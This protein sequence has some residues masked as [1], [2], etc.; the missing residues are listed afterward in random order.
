MCANRSFALRSK[1]G[2]KSADFRQTGRRPIHSRRSR[3]RGEY[4]QSSSGYNELGRK[5]YF[6]T[7]FLGGLTNAVAVGG[8]PQAVTRNQPGEIV[9]STN[10]AT[11]NRLVPRS[12][13]LADFFI[14]I[15]SR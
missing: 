2:M 8:L 15:A 4:K 13:A 12:A 14:G 11:M 9:F 6:D 1:R 7:R 3:N 5:V 10:S